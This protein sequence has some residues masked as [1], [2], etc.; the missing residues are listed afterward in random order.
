M[1]ISETKVRVRYGETDQMGYAYYGVYAQYYEIGRVE[2]LRKIGFSYKEMEERGILLPVN[3]Y[4]INFLK[5]AF[6]DD[7]IKIVTTV[8][9]LPDVRFFFSYECF[10]IQNELI[11]SGKVTLVFVNKVKNKPCRAPNWFLDKLNPYFTK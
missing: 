3:H 9:N 5:P 4:E 10:N 11:N 6:Y 7:E 2:T 1:I 8:H